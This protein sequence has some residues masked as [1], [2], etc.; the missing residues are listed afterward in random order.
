MCVSRSRLLSNEL[1][2]CIENGCSVIG[3]CLKREEHNGCTRAIAAG[4][5]RMGSENL[6]MGDSLE[7]PGT[8]SCA[9]FK[10]CLER[11]WLKG[12]GSALMASLM[13]SQTAAV[14]LVRA[15]IATSPL[16]AADM[17]FASDIVS[18]FRAESGIS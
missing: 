14:M 2:I 7:S 11:D 10:Q 8:S 17:L 5:Q 6:R 4:R 15:G 1:A 18:K 9:C 3:C 16:A 13:Q 12:E